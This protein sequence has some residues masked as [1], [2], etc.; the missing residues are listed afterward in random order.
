[1]SASGPSGI[2]LVIPV[3][4][5][6]SS[7]ATLIKSIDRQT[8]PSD[9]ILL[10]DGGSSDRTAAQA[11]ELTAGDPRY[12]VIAAGRPGAGAVHRVDDAPPRSLGDGRRLPRPPGGRGPDLHGADRPGRGA[13]RLGPGGDGPLAAPAH[14][15]PDVPPVQPVLAAQRLGR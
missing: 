12:R 8:R 5:E 10:V 2:S 4:N 15:R 6:E 14:P 9:E 3:R 1:M 7:L 13:D 11:R